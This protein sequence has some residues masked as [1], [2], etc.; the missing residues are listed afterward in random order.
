[1]SGIDDFRKFLK[2]NEHC[3]QDMSLMWII[4]IAV[5]VIA[6]LLVILMLVKRKKGGPK[7]EADAE[8]PM[9]E[10]MGQ[11]APLEE[12]SDTGVETPSVPE[13]PEVPT[14]PSPNN[15]ENL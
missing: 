7:P 1:M 11:S 8:M 6:A 15:S 4:I 9:P 5:V 3:F 2:I 12:A 10:S 13:A 14:S